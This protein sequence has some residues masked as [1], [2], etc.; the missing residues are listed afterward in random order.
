M[1]SFTSPE[2]W[3]TARQT[4]HSALAWAEHL[5]PFHA[6]KTSHCHAGA[7]ERI[8]VGRDV[9]ETCQKQQKKYKKTYFLAQKYCDANLG[10][11]SYFHCFFRGYSIAG[12]K[13]GGIGNSP[14]HGQI[15]QSHLRRPIL[16]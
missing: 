14:E 2:I 6:Q 13:H 5:Q 15:L 16:T 9:Q 4:V 10:V 11:G 8:Y 1:Q 3:P 7:F 12:V